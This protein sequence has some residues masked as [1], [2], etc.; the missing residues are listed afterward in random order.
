M[1][2]DKIVLVGA[3]N[4]YSFFLNV[5]KKPRAQHSVNTHSHDSNLVVPHTSLY[6]SIAGEL[7]I[8][9]N[10]THQGA[11]TN[12]VIWLLKLHVY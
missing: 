1:G 12:K 4:F 2:S 3:A 5:E 9:G 8:A 10:Q 11:K 7:Y 6:I